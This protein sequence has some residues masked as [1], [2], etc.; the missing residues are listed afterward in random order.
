[1]VFV[2]PLPATLPE[3]QQPKR[4]RKATSTRVTSMVTA[5]IDKAISA[6]T[7]RRILHM[8]VLYAQVHRFCVPLSVQSRWARL[9][10]CQKHGNWTVSD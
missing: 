10:W 3:L 8:N 9:K 1:M 2:P 5:S 7:V 4:N 6:V